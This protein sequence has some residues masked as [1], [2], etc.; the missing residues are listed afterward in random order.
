MTDTDFDRLE[1]LRAYFHTSE[2][3][4]RTPECLEPDTIAAL[5][6]G[7][8]DSDARA[9][10]LPHVASCALCRRAVASIVEALAQGPITH[11]I[12]VVEGRRRT[13][14]RLLRVG[15]L[16]A[17]AAAVL[18]LVRAPAGDGT[19]SH[20]GGGGEDNVV[21]VVRPIGTVAAARLFDWRRVGGSDQYRVTVFNERGA[22]LYEA[23]VA[24]SALTLP[25]SVRLE[26]GQR[27]LWRVRA[28]I[29]WDRWIASDLVAFTI[30]RGP[31]Q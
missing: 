7:T 6:D 3:R 26:A 27:Y 25:D 11:E 24:D 8:I 15:V 10:A 19:T 22:M 31:P 16:L 9:R 4:S 17:V 13:R 29:D 23:L 21:T 20:R 18:V 1:R 30:A 2:I 14:G 12:E 28:R 5:A